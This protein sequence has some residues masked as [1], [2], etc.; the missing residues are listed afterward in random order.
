MWSDRVSVISHPERSRGIVRS[1][2]HPARRST[3]GDWHTCR[4]APSR[5]R[6]RGGGLR[7]TS[8]G[9]QRS[10]GPI[11][12]RNR[13]TT[14]ALPTPAYPIFAIIRV[15]RRHPFHVHTVAGYTVWRVLSTTIF[16][17]AIWGLRTSTGLLRGEVE[18]VAGSC[19]W[20]VLSRVDGQ[21]FK[22][23]WDLVPPWS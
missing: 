5:G 15:H 1:C 14:S 13:R 4:D 2:R 18:A 20:P 17:R 12:C 21:R 22:C 16:I 9:Y 3:P 11:C 10:A 19:C 8:S 7:W 23:W 6:P